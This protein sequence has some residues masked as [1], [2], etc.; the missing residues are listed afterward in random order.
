[1][2]SLPDN[3]KVCRVEVEAPSLGKLGVVVGLLRHYPH[4]IGVFDP[5]PSF[6]DWEKKLL[7]MF[8]ANDLDIQLHDL[9][10]GETWY[11]K[12]CD[13]VLP[14]SDRPWHELYWRDERRLT[15]TQS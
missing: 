8:E 9:D 12:A 15:R 2:I 11:G 3:F 4:W 13:L 6:S 7:S 5:A 1:V 14:E 10:S